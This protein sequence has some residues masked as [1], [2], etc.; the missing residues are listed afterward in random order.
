MKLST[1]VRYG[2]RF[3][4]DLA[5]HEHAGN[6]KLKDIAA[7]QNVSEKY[8]WQVISPLKAAGLIRTAAGPGGGYRLARPAETITLR[9]ILSILDGDTGLIECVTARQAC[10]RSAA[11]AARM[12]WAELDAA[13][14]RTTR[15]ITVASLVERQRQCDAAHTASY[16]I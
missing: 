6:I 14:D 11:C 5:F 2:V 3:L 13:I 4:L 9:D 1:K 10:S 8:L 12:A 16:T 15:A 7:R